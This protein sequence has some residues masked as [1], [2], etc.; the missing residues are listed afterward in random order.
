MIKR[1][2]ECEKMADCRGYIRTSDVRADQSYVD[3]LD[4][5]AGCVEVWNEVKNE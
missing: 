3:H 5:C 4:T 2:G 1:P